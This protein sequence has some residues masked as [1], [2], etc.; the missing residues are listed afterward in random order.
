MLSGAVSIVA[1]PCLFDTDVGNC[2][3]FRISSVAGVSEPQWSADGAEFTLL[4]NSP[5]GRPGWIFGFQLTR[6]ARGTLAW[7]QQAAAPFRARPYDLIRTGVNSQSVTQQAQTYD[8]VIAALDERVPLP[9][10][11][12]WA[13][14]D[15]IGYLSEERGTLALRYAPPSGGLQ[16][17]PTT[18]ALLPDAAPALNEA[19][20]PELLGMGYRASLTGASTPPRAPFHRTVYDARTGRS[21]GSYGPGT[22]DLPPRF[23]QAGRTLE[24]ALKAYGDAWFIAATT[25][26]SSA[27]LFALARR[28]N[29]D[30][31]ILRI[32]EDAARPDRRE[33]ACASDQPARG[34]ISLTHEDWGR[35]G[36]PLSVSLYETEGA[37]TLIVFLHGGPGRNEVGGETPV[38]VQTYL[39]RGYSVAVPEYS[40]SSGGGLD[41]AGR[42]AA[43]GAAAHRLDAADLSLALQ[44]RRTKYDV[45]GLH[46]ESFG[47]AL[48]TQPG[49]EGIDFV[50]AIAPYVRHRDP[51]TWRTRDLTPAQIAYQNGG[52]AAFFGAPGSAERTG[53]ENALV[54]NL[55][56][57]APTVP[58]LIIVGSRDDVSQPSDFETVA[59]NPHVRLQVVD[60]AN[61]L[62][63]F[64]EREGETLRSFLDT[65]QSR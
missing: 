54:D 61:H 39:D 13:G 47:G 31:I 57:W 7:V 46:A 44:G 37:D 50:V 17:I 27:T 9:I 63:I 8:Q 64:N 40:G 24:A 33:I 23:E 41:L 6:D 60:R 58:T 32:T 22:L 1:L 48:M 55:A 25:L 12:Y 14:S 18:A 42:I 19:G 49:L 30:L 26:D 45:I 43:S 65:V 62:T 5:R 53:F 3:V 29:G 38:P 16:P 21:V 4:G 28:T 59:R 10:G 36:R 35:D 2:E 56:R 34:P 20:Q 52:E 15:Y 51:A 11:G